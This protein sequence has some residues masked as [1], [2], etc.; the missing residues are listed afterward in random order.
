MV[1]ALNAC[2]G[3]MQLHAAWAADAGRPGTADEMEL[4]GMV[5]TEDAPHRLAAS[6]LFVGRACESVAAMV[7]N[8]PAMRDVNHPIAHSLAAAPATRQRKA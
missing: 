2:P 5:G 4:F 1:H 6:I 7:A 8:A 3:T